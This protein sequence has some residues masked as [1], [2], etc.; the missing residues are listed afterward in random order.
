MGQRLY[1]QACAFLA[2]LLAV[3]LAAPVAFA[4]GP[5][6]RVV[7]PFLEFHTGPGR[8]YPVFHVLESGDTALI[9]KRR[10]DWFKLQADDGKTGWV[11]R[12]Q[13]ERTLTDAGVPTSFREVLLDDYLARRLEVGFVA[14]TFDGD[15]TVGLRGSYRLG[16]YMSAEAGITHVPGTFSSSTV[17]NLNL[18]S[19]PFP[20]W[21]LSPT[22]TI[23]LG[24]FDNVPQPTL[25][26]GEEFSGMSGNAG[27]GVRAF[28]S[29]HFLVRA[30]LRQHVVLVD[31]Q[32]NREFRELTAGF[33]F[34]F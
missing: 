30:D 28:L 15:S 19:G 21:R 22:L 1:T 16:E 27:I 25:L 26:A 6:I 8:G 13:M 14:G 31:D 29:R 9:L 3:L 20:N 7:E 12:A 2:V 18:V 33:A 4:D 24:Y 5:R 23:G 32:S 34:F 11:D 17:Y 10:T